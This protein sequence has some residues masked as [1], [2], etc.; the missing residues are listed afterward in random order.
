M[1]HFALAQDY[2]INAAAN[3]LNNS[4][5]GGGTD[6]RTI[7]ARIINLALGFLGTIALLIIVYGGFKWMTSNGDEEKVEEAKKLLKSAVIGLGII[8]ASWAIATFIISALGGAIGGSGSGSGCTD[9]STASCGCGGYMTCY[10]NSWGGCIGSNCSGGGGPTVCNANPASP[11]CSPLNQI[12]ATGNYCDPTSC[13]CVPQS[14]SGQAC[15]LD[16]TNATCQ[17]DNNRCGA[18]LTCDPSSC[19]C[20]GTPV[21]TA[22][23]PVGGFC[24]EDRN[25]VCTQDSDCATT[26]NTA[27]PNGAPDNFITIS[28]KNFGTYS[29]TGSQLIFEGANSPQLGVAPQTLNPACIN[30][31]T[32]TQIVIAVPGGVTNGPIKVVNKDNFNDTTDNTYGPQIPDFEANV[33]A[34][35]GLCYLS[36][37][38]GQ[39]SSA[40]GYEGINLYSGNAYFGNYQANVRG[41]DSQFNS[42]AGLAGTSTTPN[43]RAGDSGSFVI[44]NINGNRVPSNFLSFVKEPEQGEGPYII[45]FTPTA[46]S[47]GQYVTIRG[48]GFGGARGNNHVY[49]GNTEASYD[50]PDV[51]LNAV[52]RDDQIIV[53]VPA[54]LAD[55]NYTIKVSLGATTIDTQ[56][57]NPNTFQADKNLALK[58]SLCR[59]DPSRGPAATPVTLWGE[60]FG[61]VGDEGLVKFNYDK[62]ATGTIAVDG[63]ANMIQ[64]TVPDG[65]ITGPVHVVNNSTWGNE[66]NFLMGECHVD[67]D[68]GTQICCPASTYKKGRCAN[69]LAECFINIPTSVFEWSFST[70]F[71]PSLYSCAGAAGYYGSC[72]NGATCPNVPGTC[73][74]Y[75]GG[76]KVAA[77]D[78]DSTCASV[79]GCG[80]FAPNNC[81]YD[82]VSG[83]C[84]KNGTGANCDLAQEFTYQYVA[85]GKTITATT[86]ETCNSDKQWEITVA[87]R[88]PDGWTKST[89]NR[90]VS[91]SCEICS[92]P[93]TCNKIGSAGRCTSGSI[94]AAGSTCEADATSGHDKC[95]T[96]KQP[97]CDCCCQ[98]GQ[99]ARDCCAGLQCEG[100]CGAD[101]GKTS[102]ATLGRCGGCK[103]AGATPEARDAACNC[104]GHSGQYCDINNA[105]F[106]DGVCS[107]CTGLS[108]QNCTDH[109]S[110]CCLDANKTPS[111]ADDVC[112]GGSGQLISN[113][114]SSIDFG[115]C[116]YYDCSATEPTKCATTTPVKIGTYPNQQ[117]CITDCQNA[118]PCAGITDMT[119][120]LAKSTRCCFDAKATGGGAC[121]LGDKITGSA[122]AGYCAYYNC[123]TASSTPPGDPTKCATSTPAKL[124]LYPTI[125]TCSYYCANTPQGPGMSC[126]GVATSTCQS[127]ICNFPGFAC[128]LAS[129]SL[130]TSQPDCGTCCCKPGQA[131]D[132]CTALNPNLKCLADK[133]NCSGASRGLCCGC[134]SDNECGSPS[135]V[136]CGTDTC[137]QARPEIASTTPPHLATNVCRNAVVKVNFNQNM[138]I[139]SF[140]NILLLEERSYANGVCPAGTFIAKGNSLQDLL[141][142]KNANFLT[143]WYWQVSLTVKN[144]VGRLSGSVLASNNTPPAEHL[145]CAVPGTVSSENEGSSTALVFMPQ[146][147]LAA[148]SNYYLVVKGDENLNSQSGVLSL[149]EIGFTG[150]GYFDPSSGTYV[151]G[152]LIKFNNK[153]YKN[154]QIFKFTTLSDQ[155]PKAGICAVDHVTVNPVSYLFK[156]TDNALNENDINPNDKTFDTV[157]DRD[158]VFTTWAYSSDNQI[159]QPVTGYFWDYKWQIADPS[160]A[161][162][163]AVPSL[164]V[165]QSFAT[166]Q[167]GVTDN[168]TQITA[169]VDMTRF[170]GASCDSSPSC[171][172]TGSNCNNNC[173]NVYSNGD[174]VNKAADLYVFVCNNPWPPIALNGTWSP[175][176]DTG[177]NCLAGSGNCSNYNYKFY[178]C[179]DLGKTG[180]L[181]DL[182]AIVNQA[183]T[184]GQNTS[185]ICS[186]DHAPCSNLGAACGTDKNGDGQAD[187]LCVWDVLK[188]SYFFRETIPNAGEIINATD[189]KTGGEVKVD[190]N[191]SASQV[192]SFK[193][194]YLKSGQGTLMVKPVTLAS[195]TLTSN[196][197]TCSTVISGLTNNQSYIFKVS[198]VSVNQTESQL[199]NEKTT[200]P[201]DQTPPVV[202]LGFIIQP[203][204]IHPGVPV[205]NSK[206][207]FTWDAN[208][209]DTVLYRLYHGIVAHQYGESFDSVATATTLT[210]DTSQFPAGNNYFALTA[211]DA[212]NNESLK[213]SEVMT[214]I[215]AH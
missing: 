160:V 197:Y 52:W 15:N 196:V 10:G 38:K 42:P 135:T 66:L 25:K 169:K 195:C 32:D 76:T 185:L 71:G 111:T 65:A 131:N 81:S 143:R 122:D 26:C 213:S 87:G 94:C 3:G 31:W 96:L 99:S 151:A 203:K 16:T 2:G 78:C 80:D 141:A 46:G 12:C 136:G 82:S 17:P 61:R 67:A 9:G 159:L 176:N 127:E 149:Q 68:C 83:R 7:I 34:R 173:C 199:S 207:T 89:G 27:S 14:G 102:G 72:Q 172:C 180:T 115:Y 137:C 161:A 36:P 63:R 171:S 73:S 104:T 189:E 206:I 187:G 21:I 45:S 97:S 19:L 11:I 186:A 37:D 129:G 175:W 22:I 33:I 146:R 86:T 41:L 106:P 74:P 148:S 35:P 116:A 120:C 57:L 212:Y 193:I 53:K 147:L 192:A 188:E 1:A 165:N 113:N 200:T 85:G 182:P 204:I 134:S 92:S 215:P 18:Y 156:T 5:P 205:D 58:T 194:Y 101:T 23:S 167:A 208:S 50:F 8:L 84:L 95:F 56:G 91:G 191:S 150:P 118:D 174:Q 162:L 168:S 69:T 210:F 190:W 30:S 163:S 123:Q 152:D 138:D 112:R 181:D 144:L 93:L 107:D 154:S 77:G 184:R 109:S 59:I 198:V 202:P 178:Y 88:C 98:I 164:P 179:R 117:T 177:S 183:V 119:S 145:Y 128:L 48:Y 44:N 214:S 43:I 75:S 166:A 24:Q 62:S 20:T 28:G 13:L 142:Y 155:G 49:F 170:L 126:A 133:G 124:G 201:T 125:D 103:S 157:S 79:S 108:A 114:P 139:T 121:R 40:V 70:G 140:S 132:A 51:C 130:G 105:Q 4:L 47:A 110:A 64:T 54:G 55:G 90:C 211:L 39:L 6:L 158:K 100:T 29:A 153:S 60:Y 209:D